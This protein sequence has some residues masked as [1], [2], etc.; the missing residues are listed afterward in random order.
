MGFASFQTLQPVELGRVYGIAFE[1][2]NKAVNF[3]FCSFFFVC[4]NR[5]EKKD[6][7]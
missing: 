4:R 5:C 6:M 2:F 3:H 1:K 7:N